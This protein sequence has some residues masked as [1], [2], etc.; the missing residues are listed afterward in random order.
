MYNLVC[1]DD[2]TQYEYRAT[3]V[4]A[5]KSLTDG[6]RGIAEVTD[7]AMRELLVYRNGTLVKY[8]WETRAGKSVRA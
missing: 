6:T 5:A 2:V 7:E 8:V 3:A 1:N 4:A